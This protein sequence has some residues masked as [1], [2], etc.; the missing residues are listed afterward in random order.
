MKSFKE[1]NIIIEGR[2]REEAERARQ[3][4]H[5]PGIWTLENAGSS[6]NPSWRVKK[7]SGGSE[8][9][10]GG[11]ATASASKA[12]EKAI[13]QRQVA[14]AAQGRKKTVPQPVTKKPE[15]KPAPKKPVAKKPSDEVRCLGSGCKGSEHLGPP[16]PATKKVDPPSRYDAAVSSSRSSKKSQDFYRRFDKKK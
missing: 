7:K 12:S 1:F 9:S 3:A 2:S 15:A 5:N 11:R 16:K 14:S 6:I 8:G 13:Q 10:S 4:K